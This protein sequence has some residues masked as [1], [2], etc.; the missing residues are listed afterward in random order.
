MLYACLYDFVTIHVNT[1]R[2]NILSCIVS[3]SSFSAK[4]LTLLYSGELGYRTVLV[5]RLHP[6]FTDGSKKSD[7][8][9]NGIDLSAT[10]CEGSWNGFPSP[11]DEGEC[12]SVPSGHW[13]LASLAIRAVPQ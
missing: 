13:P 4:W 3:S 5:N 11:P 10:L 7:G 2:I 1:Y 9:C 6:T 8:H 12:L